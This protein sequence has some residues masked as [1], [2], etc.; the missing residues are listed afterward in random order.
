MAI[1]FKKK[2]KERGDRFLKLIE[3]NQE[4]L[5]KMAYSYVKNKDDALDIVQDAIYKA[6]ISYN[7]VKN[8]KYEK[9]WLIRILIN[10][11]LDF[12]RKRKK[13][14]SLDMDY[15]ENVV[16]TKS[17]NHHTK[18]M[19]EEALDKLNEKQKTVII[20]RYFEDMKLNDIAST[21]NTPVS[22]I[23]SILYRALDEMKIYIKE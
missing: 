7:K 14:L 16:D 19:L 17:E 2:D 4:Q 21:L 15:M 9:T 12:I 11:S 22:T 5:Y 23:K 3:E 8:A 6:Y 18:L 20:L 10:T 13:M 1:T